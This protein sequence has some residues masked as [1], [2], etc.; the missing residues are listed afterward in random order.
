MPILDRHRQG[1]L[2]GPVPGLGIR[3]ALD[4]QEPDVRGV[5]RYQ[6][7]TPGSSGSAPAARASRAVDSRLLRGSKERRSPAGC[8]IEAATVHLTACRRCAPSPVRLRS[9]P[10]VCSIP[11][12]DYITA[13]FLTAHGDIK[14]GWKISIPYAKNTPK[15]INSRRPMLGRGNRCAKRPFLASIGEVMVDAYTQGMWDPTLSELCHP[16]SRHRTRPSEAERTRS[17]LGSLGPCSRGFSQTL[18]GSD[19]ESVSLQPMLAILKDG[20]PPAE[21]PST[22]GRSYST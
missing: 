5:G 4:E 15:T 11:R 16:H 17:P 21:P 3:T 9:T 14:K 20:R 10:G 6:S 19:S 8:H 12:L 22:R 1:C 7:S 13:L 2:T 18:T